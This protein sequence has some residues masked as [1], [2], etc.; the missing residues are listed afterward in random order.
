MAKDEAR[1]DEVYYIVC[2]R[3]EDWKGKKT[4]TRF[5]NSYKEMRGAISTERREF[6]AFY[7]K[8]GQLECLM[9]DLSMASNKEHPV[10]EVQTF[11]S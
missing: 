2:I 5:V 9:Q 8:Q 4:R 7:C 1:R 11:N 6:D 3:K 10:I